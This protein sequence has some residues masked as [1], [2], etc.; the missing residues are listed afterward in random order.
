MTRRV[1]RCYLLLFLTKAQL[2]HSSSRTGLTIS[3]MLPFTSSFHQLPAG[4]PSWSSPLS[5]FVM[6]MVQFS[7]HQL[8][9][10]RPNCKNF[11]FYDVHSVSERQ[12]IPC[13][14]PW[15]TAAGALVLAGDTKL[16][17]SQL[18]SLSLWLN[19]WCPINIQMVAMD[20]RMLLC[21]VFY[22]MLRCNRTGQK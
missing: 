18:V 1:P 2:T 12:T 8:P 17:S 6:V 4:W 19:A 22:M 20:S 5:L 7:L 3:N 21:Y 11:T 9:A 14:W 10:G 15:Q 16:Y 13:Q